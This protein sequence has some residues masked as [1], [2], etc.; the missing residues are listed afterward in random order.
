MKKDNLKLAYEKKIIDGEKKYFS[1]KEKKKIVFLEYQI[2]SYFF[3][4]V[5]LI[6]IID[7]QKVR[8]FSQNQIHNL[9]IY[10]ERKLIQKENGINTYEKT[11]QR[12]I[13]LP[14][15]YTFDNSEYYGG[16]RYSADCLLNEDF[17][18]IYPKTRNKLKHLI[19]ALSDILIDTHIQS[20]NPSYTFISYYATMKYEI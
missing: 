15:I 13:N 8:Y 16:E 18:F 17:K 20:M 19:Q 4:N 1:Y 12:S 5:N 2:I 6:G 10:L 14:P 9:K 7:S 3:N 11:K